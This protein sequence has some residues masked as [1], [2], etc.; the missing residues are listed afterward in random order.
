MEEAQIK[1]IKELREEINEI[2]RQMVE[3]FM[4]RMR[5]HFQ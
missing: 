2:D 5:P 4:K 1:N 3:L